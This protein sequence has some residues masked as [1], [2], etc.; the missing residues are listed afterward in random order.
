[1]PIYNLKAKLK[2]HNN[3]FF[4]H[5]NKLQI[6][7]KLSIRCSLFIV[8]CGHVVRRCSMSK[9][10]IF[11]FVVVVMQQIFTLHHRHRVWMSSTVPC[12]E[13][14]TCNQN[15]ER[16]RVVW[17]WETQ[18]RCFTRGRGERINRR[19]IGGRNGERMGEDVG[20]RQRVMWEKEKDRSLI[21]ERLGERG[22]WEKKGKWD[23]WRKGEN[24]WMW[25]E[26]REN[27]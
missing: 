15:C 18:G 25:T 19:E 13:M 6:K 23:S 22:S 12:M 27:H 11:L 5:K 21:Y 16:Q 8:W 17:K 9:C 1:M 3:S 4:S 20:G 2:F 14:T 7:E 26:E 10:S 24:E